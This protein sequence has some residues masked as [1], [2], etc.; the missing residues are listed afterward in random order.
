MS[1]SN[2]G[3]GAVDVLDDDLELL[4]LEELAKLWKVS[5]RTIEVLIA[6]GE[7]PSRK[8][9]WNRRVARRDA[10]AYMQRGDVAS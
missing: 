6:S 5:K 7:L 4:K 10:L 9:G 1:H 3:V 8:I 2:A